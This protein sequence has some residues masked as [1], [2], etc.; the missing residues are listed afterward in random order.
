MKKPEL[1]KKHLYALGLTFG[2]VLLVC[3]ATLLFGYGW[4]FWRHGPDDIIAQNKPVAVLL[5]ALGDD[6][7]LTGCA[8]FIYDPPSKR[9]VLLGVPVNARL[10]PAGGAPQLVRELRADGVETQR[11]ALAEFC[12][13]DLPFHLEM[14]AVD[15][16][17][18]VDLLRGLE[19]RLDRQLSATVQG[20][21]IVLP[22]ERY[23]FNSEKIRQYLAYTMAAEPAERQ[24]L[25][26]RLLQGFAQQLRQQK[27]FLANPEVWELVTEW[28]NSDLTSEEIRQLALK[29][30][31]CPGESLLWQGLPGSSEISGGTAVF[32][33]GAPD[34]TALLPPVAP[35]PAAEEPLPPGVAPPESSA[36]PD[37][38][39]PAGPR[40]K[41]ALLNGTGVSGVA[42]G[43]RQQLMPFPE[44]DIVEVG[45]ADNANYR[46]TKI[47]ARAGSL[48]DAQRVRDRLGFGAPVA[49][50]AAT[51]L[52]DVTI[53]IGKDYIERRNSE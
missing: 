13:F 43:I 14:T 19:V 38:A 34:L 41:I 40:L 9:V 12:R 47:I 26:Q 7:E 50:A 16:Y 20:E 25:L 52:V 2:I 23:R 37:A 33:P 11:R 28:C 8:I 35:A 17:R 29:L 21:Q 39:A 44:I 45:N 10:T 48:A 36:A 42:H 32:V 31:A 4:R 1:E 15:F 3:L 53:I 6:R 46:Q 5:N 22:I 49:E 30:A 51:A 24:D 18:L 27:D